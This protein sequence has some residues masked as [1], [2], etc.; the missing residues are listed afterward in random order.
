MTTNVWIWDDYRDKWSH[1]VFLNDHDATTYAA[2][3]NATGDRAEIREPW[4]P[5]PLPPNCEAVIK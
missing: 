3:M 2:R 1:R 5:E 4:E